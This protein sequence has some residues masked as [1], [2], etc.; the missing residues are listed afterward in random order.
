MSFK[1]I[2]EATNEICN[3]LTEKKDMLSTTESVN[4][5]LSRILDVGISKSAVF[6]ATTTS[7]VNIGIDPN[8][9]SFLTG[10]SM[11]GNSYGFEINQIDGSVKNVTGRIIGMCTGS[12]S[13]QPNKEGGRVTQ[14]N[15]WSERS[16]DGIQWEQNSDS[17]RTL[18][19]SNSGETFKTTI[20]FVENWGINEY[21]RFRLYCPSA[22][23][24]SFIS[25]SDTVLG[26]E[27][28]VGSSVIWELSE[29]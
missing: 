11:S 3:L 14:I 24:L 12:I 13:F 6:L 7:E 5:I 29:K 15:M 17:L 26:G 4:K 22:K 8:T 2:V 20:S 25:P 16:L 27:T 1:S 28:I 23:G 18:E 9:P 19:I 10:M 21:I